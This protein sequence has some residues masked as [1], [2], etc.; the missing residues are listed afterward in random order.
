MSVAKRPDL[1]PIQVQKCAEWARNRLGD[2]SDFSKAERKAAYAELRA[3]LEKFYAEKNYSIADKKRALDVADAAIESIEKSHGGKGTLVDS[4]FSKVTELWAYT[5]P[6][7]IAIG[8]VVSAFADFFKPVL[9]LTPITT[10]VAGIATVTLGA[11]STRSVEAR[12]RLRSFAAVCGVMFACS[13][14]FWGL[15]II[16]PG[17]KTE[18]AIAAVVPGLSTIQDR[19]FASL[20]RI[21]DAARSGKREVSA[22][23]RK[24]LFNLGMKYDEADFMKAYFMCDKRALSLYKQAGMKIPRYKAIE[25]LTNAPD[26]E[27]I[28]E[29]KDDFVAIGPDIC[30]TENY[31]N[32]MMRLNV[33][34]IEWL[35]AGFEKPEKKAFIEEICGAERLK[36]E[37]PR[38]YPQP[39]RS[40]PPRIQQAASSL[41]APAVTQQQAPAAQQA[42]ATLPAPA[43][44]QTAM[45]PSSTPAPADAATIRANSALTAAEVRAQIVGPTKAV[46]HN[47]Q[48][49][50]TY[51]ADGKFDGGDGRLGTSGTYRVEPD[52]RLCWKN[53]R[54]TSGCFQYYRQN[55]ALFVRR[56]DGGNTAIIGPVKVSAR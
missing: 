10:I 38:L 7:L 44:P 21:E 49:D 36:A 20:D 42:P 34:A 41:P 50:L 47:G 27:C 3:T 52:G 39:R 6:S 11:L 35:R 4:L 24:E 22:D 9:E 17:A 37:Y 46:N 56:N 45:A 43:Q 1:D 13:A 25:F 26:I 31:V 19:L 33:P 29:F 2:I 14:G 8:G 18:G 48:L 53:S 30:L 55:G 23:P 28:R 5:S 12:S 32:P 51:G 16:V 15:Q 40:E 54:G